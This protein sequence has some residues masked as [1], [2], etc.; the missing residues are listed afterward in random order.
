M[1]KTDLAF[2]SCFAIFNMS[3]LFSNT[4]LTF[5]GNSFN[6]SIFFEISSVPILFL[7]EASFNP[8]KKRTI[9]WAVK[10]FVAATPISGP[11]CNRI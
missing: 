7:I 8:I 10:V 4:S 3:L 11:D 5:L 1:K 9:I 2:L 6:S